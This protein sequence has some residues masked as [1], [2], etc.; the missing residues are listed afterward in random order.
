MFFGCHFKSDKINNSAIPPFKF[1]YNLRI[2]IDK[3]VNP[4]LDQTHHIYISKYSREGISAEVS[5][6]NFGQIFQILHLS[7]PRYHADSQ[8]F[9]ILFTIPARGAPAIIV[10]FFIVTPPYI[11]F[12]IRF[13]NQH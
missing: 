1:S 3:H 13:Y 8:I 2:V 12:L 11:N 4:C 9:F 6:L 5:I 7:N 10:L